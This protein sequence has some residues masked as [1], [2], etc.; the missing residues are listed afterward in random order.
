MRSPLALISTRWP[1]LLYMTMNFPLRTTASCSASAS[2]C[3]RGALANSQMLYMSSPVSN[4]L[5]A[6]LLGLIMTVLT[7]FH[8][9]AALADNKERQGVIYGTG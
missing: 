6:W 7:L 4:L 1:G 3:T 9:L 8:I 2:E 5:L